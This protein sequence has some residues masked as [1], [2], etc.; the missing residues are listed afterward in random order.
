MTYFRDGERERKRERQR[1]FPT[2]DRVPVFP[3]SLGYLHISG[4]GNLLL[5]RHIG[6]IRICIRTGTFLAVQTPSHW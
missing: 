4:E 6:A 5:E 3:R 1:K 2:S